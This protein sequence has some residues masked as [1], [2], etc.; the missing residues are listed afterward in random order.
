MVQQWIKQTASRAV[1]Q[2]KSGRL[3]AL[4]RGKDVLK[5]TP[6]FLAV[7]CTMVLFTALGIPFKEQNQNSG[8]RSL[9]HVEQRCQVISSREDGV[10]QG[11][12]EDTKESSLREEGA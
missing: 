10:L 6:E 5:V 9:A 12:H 3:S 7:L 2:V 4:T 8:C 11:R 1:K